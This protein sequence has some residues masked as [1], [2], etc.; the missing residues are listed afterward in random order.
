MLKDSSLLR[1]AMS[2][3]L[4]LILYFLLSCMY[5][6]NRNKSKSKPVLHLIMMCTVTLAWGQFNLGCCWFNTTT[7]PNEV[8][9]IL[10]ISRKLH[11]VSKW[12]VVIYIYESISLIFS[13]ITSEMH[14][15]QYI[16]LCKP[17]TILR[18]LAWTSVLVAS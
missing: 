12:Y 13:L 3:C 6:A 1:Y 2:I 14:C 16:T 8:H 11:L 5:I 9:H 7:I 17:R 10:L 4:T 18:R 15:F